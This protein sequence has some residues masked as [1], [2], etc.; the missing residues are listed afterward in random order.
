MI[1]S[2]VFRS[3]PGGFLSGKKA[4]FILFDDYAYSAPVGDSTGINGQT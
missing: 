2:L 3:R 4:C 1:R